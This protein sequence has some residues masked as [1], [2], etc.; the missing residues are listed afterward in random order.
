MTSAARE[1][2]VSLAELH[3]ILKKRQLP[4]RETLF[5]IAKGIGI[6]NTHAYILA[7]LSRPD[8]PDRI[9]ELLNFY[10]EK[11]I[12]APNL[13]VEEVIKELYPQLDP[14]RPVLELDGKILKKTLMMLIRLRWATEYW[15]IAQ[16]VISS[17][18][19]MRD[20]HILRWSIMGQEEYLGAPKDFAKI[21]RQFDRNG[22]KGVKIAYLDRK[23]SPRGYV[24]SAISFPRG[25]GAFE[26]G[27]ATTYGFEMGMVIR[28][29]G[30]FL[31][32]GLRKDEAFSAQPFKEMMTIVFSRL[33]SHCIF[34]TSDKLELL[35]IQIPFPSGH[36]AKLPVSFRL[37]RDNA[38]ILYN[39]P[40]MLHTEGRNGRDRV[41]EFR[42][43]GARLPEDLEKLVL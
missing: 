34:V 8:T 22:K 14:S 18:L 19:A 12:E 25:H 37:S 35:N 29:E 7:E 20:E 5:H 40:T 13:N 43:Q 15:N 28:G 17:L 38:R 2:G 4:K 9:I 33:R 42:A 16:G 26:P 23:E 21:M 10:Y 36:S 1:L 39:V 11:T 27:T 41:T 3:N 32:K 30:V 31:S 6:S 24:M